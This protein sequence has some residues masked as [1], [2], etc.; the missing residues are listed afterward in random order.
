MYLGFEGDAAPLF[1]ISRPR[2]V[3][4]RAAGKATDS[5]TRRTYQVPERNTRATFVS[6]HLFSL[7]AHKLVAQPHTAAIGLAD[8]NKTHAMQPGPL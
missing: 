7:T 6:R 1:S 2:R 4:R 3:E 5:P 8:A